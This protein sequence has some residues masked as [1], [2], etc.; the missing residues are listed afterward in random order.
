MRNGYDVVVSNVSIQQWS[1][2]YAGGTTAGQATQKVSSFMMALNSA[3]IKASCDFY[4][5][6]DEQL[7]ILPHVNYK[8]VLAPEEVPNVLRQ[9][10][11]GFIYLPLGSEKGGRVAQK[12]YD[13]IST[14]VVPICFRPS[15]EMCNMIDELQLGVK[16]FDEDKIDSVID[17]LKHTQFAPSHLALQQLSRFNQFE[18]LYQYIHEYLKTNQ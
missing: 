2:I 9:Y 7:A 8:G 4:G 16:V 15:I 11:F 17:Q 1:F 12:F 5:E 13:Y 18:K 14:G 10:R 6:Y 3:G